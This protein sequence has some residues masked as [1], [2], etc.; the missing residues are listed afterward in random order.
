VSEPGDERRDERPNGDEEPGA[1]EARSKPADTAPAAAGARSEGGEVQPPSHEIT[2]LELVWRHAWV[3]AAAYVVLAVLVV[4]VLWSLRSSYAFA[5]QVGVIGFVVAYILNPIVEALGR[6]RVR[7]SIA[8]VLVYLALLQVFVFGS[9]L[10]AQVVGELGR[11]INLIPSAVESLGEQVARLGAWT[12]GIVERLPPFVTDFLDERLG[13]QP[14]GG[15]LGTQA[16]ERIA[17]VLETAVQNLL[18]LFER[19]LEEGPS[20]LL[21]G[22]TSIVST[23]LQAFLILLASAY[24]LY[25]FPRFTGNVRRF[26]PIRWRSLSNDLLSKADRAVG[27]YLRGQ[28]LITT[29]LGV[30]IWIGLSLI[31]IPLATA[32]SFLAAIFNLVPYLGPIVGT[33]P[34]VLLGFTVS[35][36]AAVLAVVV[37]VVANQLEGNVLSPL[38]LS[39][40]VDLHPVTVLLAIMAGLGL[41]GFLGALLAVPTVALTKVV[42]EDYLLTRPAYTGGDGEAG[43]GG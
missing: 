4:L 1:R 23:T 21:S 8:T 34:A 3:R 20:A 19:L 35:P 15:E 32:I 38:I 40:S 18:Q 10:V 33:I 28:L 42:L 25:D 17:R 5:L 39:R 24:F 36:W 43:P 27:G 12:E 6:I 2:A 29:I 7:R 41:L 14:D 26:V 16:Q 22:A 37:F 30:M 9:I 13:V 31:G 11:F